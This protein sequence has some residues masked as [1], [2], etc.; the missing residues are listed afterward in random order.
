MSTTTSALASFEEALEKVR[1][2][3]VIRQQNLESLST[4]TDSSSVLCDGNFRSLPRCVPDQG[5]GL[6]E[7]SDF[8]FKTVEPLLNPGHSGPRYFGFVTGGTLPSAL[9]ADWFTSLYDQNVQV[10]LPKETCSTVI[11]AFTMEMIIDL[12]GLNSKRFSGTLTTGATGSNL[13]AL[14]C[15]RE[16]TTKRCMYRRSGIA[17]WSAAEYGLSGSDS[18]TIQVFVC[19]A[20]ASIRKTAAL[21]GIGRANVIDVGKTAPTSTNRQQ[22]D[23]VCLE[24]D[25]KRLE[26]E[27]KRRYEAKEPSIVVVGM[28]EV[29]TGALS[30]QT[31]K[32]RQL[33]N[34][35]EAWLHVDAGEQG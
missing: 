8:L 16:E 6:S 22:P 12:L 27:L 25:L 28:G 19:Q 35:Y 23:V 15:A 5:W 3:A 14:I 11:E 32:L 33:C 9:I 4:I 21:A 30:D 17:D 34:K 1:S 20:H 29:V 18:V 2:L 26:R 7:A 10:H 31:P 13:L 24:F